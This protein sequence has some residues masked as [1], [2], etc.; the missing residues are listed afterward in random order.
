MQTSFQESPV[1]VLK[2]FLDSTDVNNL[3]LVNESV[4]GSVC[5]VDGRDGHLAMMGISVVIHE[6]FACLGTNIGNERKRLGESFMMMI[7]HAHPSLV[8]VD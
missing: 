2:A 5:I 7:F 3:P 1:G 4:L 6:S 8:I